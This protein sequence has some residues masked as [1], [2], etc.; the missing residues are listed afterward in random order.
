MVSITK[1]L[2]KINIFEPI[3]T[4]YINI[5]TSYDFAIN[6]EKVYVFHWKEGIVDQVLMPR[7]LLFKTFHRA[8]RYDPSADTSKITSGL[9]GG[10]F[11]GMFGFILGYFLGNIV[12]SVMFLLFFGIVGTVGGL[13]AISPLIAKRPIWIISENEK[14]FFG[15]VHSRF[16]N[17]DIEDRHPPEILYDKM[18][19]L[20][21]KESIKIGLTGYQ[22][23]ALGTLVILAISCLIAL[24]LFVGAFATG[25]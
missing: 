7:E 24:F 19:N 13:L 22:K 11:V 21:M 15:I 2:S 9:F 23:L 10:L 18:E 25:G 20:D 6:L 12:T 8:C 5:K 1:P 16:E 14:S 4:F 17:S 3:K